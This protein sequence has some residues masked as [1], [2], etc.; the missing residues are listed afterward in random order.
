MRQNMSKREV[1]FFLVGCERS[2]T[3]LLRLMLNEH[4]N[5]A[6]P[7]ES[8]FIAN[9]IERFGTQRIL[10]KD[11]V[12]EAYN[13]IVNLRRW[14]EWE[15]SR[16]AL[17]TKL[18]ILENPTIAQVVNVV[19]ELK[20]SQTGKQLWGD[21]TPK[22]SNYIDKIHNMYPGAKFIHL[23]RDGRDV[24]L[25]FLKTNWIGPWVSRI[26]KYWS[27]RVEA[28]KLSES[29]L[30]GTRYLEIRY[31]ELVCQTEDTLRKICRFLEQDYAPGMLEYSGDFEKNVAGRSVVHHQKLKRKPQIQ[32]INRWKNELGWWK[33]L[34]FEAFAKEDLKSCGYACKF[35]HSGI[36]LYP[37]T[38]WFIAMLTH[39]SKFR[40]RLRLTLSMGDTINK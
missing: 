3:T 9:L 40:Q 34:T 19:F 2:G 31:E 13:I 14:Q 39:T 21:K 25:S 20:L 27:N 4:P 23:T 6:M 15:N 10:S 33:I 11:E 18:E 26:A 8:H 12:I 22:Y 29:Y 30:T 5:I 37:L 16:E 24:C 7:A 32:D 36:L 38:R 1:S 17:L 35:R 28:A